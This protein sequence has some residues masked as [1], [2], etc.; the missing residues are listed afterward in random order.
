MPRG[1][2]TMGWNV[3]GLAIFEI[4]GVS[5]EPFNRRCPYITHR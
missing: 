2:G 3:R 4:E 1:G 5:D